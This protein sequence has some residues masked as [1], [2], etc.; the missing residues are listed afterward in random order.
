[1]AAAVSTSIFY[2]VVVLV[3]WTFAVL[4]LVPRARFRAAR[5]KRVRAADFAFGESENVPARARL[6]NRNYM[7]LLELPV[8]FYVACL[9]VYVI[10]KVDAWS[11]G[12]AWLYVVLR[13]AHSLVHLTYN[14]VIHRMRVFALGAFVLLALWIRILAVL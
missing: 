4:L 5:E 11:L 9:L 6:P 10:G 3:L 7:N 14:H 13:I 2:P 12:L 1:M 8:L